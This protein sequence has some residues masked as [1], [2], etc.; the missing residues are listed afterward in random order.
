MSMPEDHFAWRV[1]R[2]TTLLSML[3]LGTALLRFAAPVLA[4]V[5]ESEQNGEIAVSDKLRKPDKEWSKIL[6]PEQYQILREGGT[7]PAFCGKYWDHHE[8]GVY[9]CAA[10][11]FELFRSDTKF[12]SG[13]GWPSFTKAVKEDRIRKITDT[14]HGMVRTEAVCSRCE[15]HL[16][17]VFNDGPP[18]T[19]L[20]YCINSTALNFTADTNAVKPDNRQLQIATFGAGCFWCTDAVFQMLPGVESVKVGYMGGHTKNP[21]YE[22]VCA[23][24][25]GYAEVAQITYDP[26]KIAYDRLLDIFWKIHDPTSLN[27]Q[28]GDS[29]TQYRSVIFY[30]SDNQK[31]AAER[32]KATWQKQLRKPIVTEIGAATNFYE[33]DSYHQNYYRNNRDAPYC[34][35]VI[36]PKLNKIRP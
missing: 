27:K 36:A 2:W 7:E 15:A 21:T 1:L 22:L 35:Q 14:S 13:T 25:T 5:E 29:G 24:D 30:H 31:Q 19:G 12:D 23:G 20:R 11:G 28:E 4:G 6:T 16:G 9:R 10:C 18:P 32:S 8:A 33:A 26:K 3:T 17:H 34:R